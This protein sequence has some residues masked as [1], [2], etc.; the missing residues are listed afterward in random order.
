M[1]V[2]G[3][4]VG[5]EI[6]DAADASDDGGK[7][8]DVRETDGDAE[9]LALGEMRDLDGA[10]VAVDL[11][12]A[13]IDSVF[14]DFDSGDGAGREIGEHGVPVVG[15][16]ITETEHDAG[17]GGDGVRLSADGAGWTVKEIMEDFVESAE[18]AETGC[19]RNFGHGHLGFVDELL[20]E[21]DAAGLCNGDGRGSEMLEEEAAELAIT[22]T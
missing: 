18:A 9:A 22:D 7:R 12:G 14:D 1:L 19:E 17:V 16:A 3:L 2:D 6:E 15:R 4:D 21:E 13:L 10:D 8:F 5:A 20:G 11:D